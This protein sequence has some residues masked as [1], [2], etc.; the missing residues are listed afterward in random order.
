MD[1]VIK[2]VVTK[3]AGYHG[4]LLG[5]FA[6][7]AASLLVLG[8]V[9]TRATI[10]LRVAE[11]LQTSLRQVV[12]DDLHDNNLLANRINI[13]NEGS[14]IIVY[15][16][17]KNNSVTAVAFSVSGQGYGGEIKLIMGINAAGEILG[18]RVISHAETPGLGDLIEAEKNPWIFS[19]NGHSLNN[20]AEDKWKVKKD[21]GVFD[22]FSGATI[23]PRAV[24][25]AIKAGLDMFKQNHDALLMIK[26][27]SASIRQATQ[28][29]PPHEQ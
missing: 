26:E 25:K 2:P 24:V 18:V 8:Y 11:D 12:P 1:E 28:E 21:G 15:Q 17:I 5:G 7:L 4:I 20:P 23:T 16:G 3:H 14:E 9:S 22:Q 10:D 13:K 29:T 6:T 27:S 19:F